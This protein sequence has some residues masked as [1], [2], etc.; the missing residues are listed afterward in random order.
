M[1]CS[2]RKV[3]NLVKSCQ[4]TRRFLI[5]VTRNNTTNNSSKLI[6][7]LLQVILIK[8]WTKSLSIMVLL[9]TFA[10]I[11]SAH[12]YGT[13]KS[14]CHVIHRARALSTMIGQMAMAF[15]LTGFNDLG[16]SVTPTFLFRNRFNLQLSTHCPKMNKN[17]NVGS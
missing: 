7:V 4:V 15:A 9:R 17:I 3:R 10:L 11:F 12:P 1:G 8:C 14:T 6:F 13:R 16:R 5:A 2:S